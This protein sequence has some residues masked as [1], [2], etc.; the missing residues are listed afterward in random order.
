MV[1]SS[2]EAAVLIVVPPTSV[3]LTTF[4]SGEKF[5]A[6][7]LPP[8]LVDESSINFISLAPFCKCNSHPPGSIASLILALLSTIAYT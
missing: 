3:P 7:V 4:N 8:A 6:F 1:E 2:A 5:R